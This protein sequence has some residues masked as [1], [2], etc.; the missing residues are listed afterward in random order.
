MT[1]PPLP[2]P[3][4]ASGW[5]APAPGWS[6][7]EAGVHSPDARLPWAEIA[8]FVA[9]QDEEG[10]TDVRVI[11]R[12]GRSRR[13]PGLTRTPA[14]YAHQ[15]GAAQLRALNAVA[16]ARRRPSE[17]AFPVQLRTETGTRVGAAIG[18]TVLAAL[19]GLLVAVTMYSAVSGA[20]F[21]ALFFLPMAA[22]TGGVA[23]LM[24][25]AG[26][27]TATITDQEVVLRTPLRPPRR[28]PLRD[29]VGFAHHCRGPSRACSLRTTVPTGV[30]HVAL[31]GRDPEYRLP[32]L[33]A[34]VRERTAHH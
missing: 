19:T 31:P 11:T 28:I 7:D 27:V 8:E 4:P 16:A 29:V 12:D 1:A 23:A 21:M 25:R 5:P 20:A 17:L 18:V 10:Y 34:Y 14:Q 26:W 2:E 15:D 32:A 30:Q 9:I 22:I 24:L 3:A 13:I 6:I 33:D